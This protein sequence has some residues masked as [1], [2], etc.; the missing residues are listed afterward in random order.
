MKYGKNVIKIALLS[1]FFSC[2]STKEKSK[3]TE[4]ETEVKTETEKIRY[5]YLKKTTENQKL[6]FVLNLDSLLLNRYQANSQDTGFFFAELKNGKI[7]IVYIQPKTTET[8]EE[9]TKD[10]QTKKE[11]EKKK[12]NLELK[13]E[14]K[15][16]SYLEITLGILLILC[17][18]YII[19]SK[20]KNFTGNM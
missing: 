10:K 5:S 3:I 12:E 13:K 9:K 17:G 6:N 15:N 11:T 7:E 2:I 8:R 20:R 19:Y 16:N 1:S 18:F 4:K 14:T